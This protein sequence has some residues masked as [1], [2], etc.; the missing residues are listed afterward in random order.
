MRRF[1][2]YAF[3]ETSSISEAD[4]KLKT[5]S[6][7]S[8]KMTNWWVIRQLLT[9]VVKCWRQFSK[10][11]EILKIKVTRRMWILTISSRPFQRVF[12]R[13]NRRRYSRERIVKV[14][15]RKAG[16]QVTNKARQVTN[17]IH[18]NLGS[19]GEQTRFWGG[20]ESGFCFARRKQREHGC[21]FDQG[22]GPG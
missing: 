3:S 22:Y 11:C 10:I 13:K 19:L 15:D 2:F 7:S 4:A 8:P 16:I 20:R 21:L 14:W 9:N 6:Y 1:T 17:R 18:R 12:D 5:I